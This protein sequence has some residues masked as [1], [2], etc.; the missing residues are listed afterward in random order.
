MSVP[1]AMKQQ[2]RQQPM[3]TETRTV[4]IAHDGKEFDNEEYALEHERVLELQGCL[5]EADIIDWRD[6]SP[7]EVAS[8]LVRFFDFTPKEQQ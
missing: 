6:T 4:F 1:S 8:Y 5:E 2:R 7:E 3:R